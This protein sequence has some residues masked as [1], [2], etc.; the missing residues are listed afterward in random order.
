LVN[1]DGVL[2]Y[3]IVSIEKHPEHLGVQKQVAGVL[4][5]LTKGSKSRPASCD[6]CIAII[7]KQFIIVLFKALKW[8]NANLRSLTKAERVG[9]RGSCFGDL[10]EYVCSTLRN[11]VVGLNDPLYATER[12][13]LE[14]DNTE[15]AEERKRLQKEIKK[16]MKNGERLNHIS[17]AKEYI[18]G[19]SFEKTASFAVES[20]LNILKIEK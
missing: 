8:S 9:A 15:K 2:K 17:K 6:I 4:H 7:N 5:Y 18:V 1:Q 19:C 20:L 13:R 12:W 14:D 16:Q 10:V 11:L 3:L